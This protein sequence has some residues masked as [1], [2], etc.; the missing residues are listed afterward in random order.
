MS[1]ATRRARAYGV[2]RFH[3][4]G[5]V[6][7]GV[8]TAVAAPS[9]AECDIVKRFRDPLFSATCDAARGEPASIGAHDLA[10]AAGDPCENETET[11]TGRRAKPAAFA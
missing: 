6:R 10:I 7:G 5:I 4:Q 8:A 1:R 9:I 11:S 3:D 2:K